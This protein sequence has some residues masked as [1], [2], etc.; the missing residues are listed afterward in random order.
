[1]VITIVTR[2]RI[3]HWVATVIT[4]TTAIVITTITL[5]YVVY[6]VSIRLLMEH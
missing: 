5:I 1:M 4:I 6:Q 3:N 2:G